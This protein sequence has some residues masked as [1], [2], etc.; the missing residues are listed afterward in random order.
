MRLPP[1][2]DVFQ[3]CIKGHQSYV[4]FLNKESNYP[5]HY[6]I[7]G[8]E[9]PDK[10]EKELNR[11]LG[12]GAWS[13]Y[14][15][16]GPHSYDNRNMEL[17]DTCLPN[18]IEYIPWWSREGASLSNSPIQLPGQK[19]RF[20]YGQIKKRYTSR[21]KVNVSWNY[22]YDHL[23]NYSNHYTLDLDPPFQRCHVWDLERQIKYVE[24]I[25]AG[26]QTAKEIYFN[27]PGWQGH[28]EVGQMVLVDGKQRLQAVTLF[29]D[30]ELEVFG[31]YTR[32]E[33]LGRQPSDAEFIF[34]V[35]DLETNA[36]VLEW[37]IQI[38]EGLVPHTKEELDKVKLMLEDSE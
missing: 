9:Q 36:Q 28:G 31:G 20:S 3:S 21:Y 8:T 33:I 26:G 27:A 4:V 24:F 11:N 38:N 23:K 18:D 2:N 14:R 15:T 29:L 37:Y 19:P 1:N 16:L 5:N 12:V 30:D 17:L 25:L 7:F 32:S 13:N 34:Y 6:T 35:N 22:L 10:L